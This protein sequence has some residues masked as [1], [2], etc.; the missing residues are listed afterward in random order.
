[1]VSGT[2]DF[3]P[4]ITETQSMVRIL[5]AHFEYHS[6]VLDVSFKILY[7]RFAFFV[8]SRRHCLP[9]VLNLRFP[10]ASPLIPMNLYHLYAQIYASLS[11]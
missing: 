2:I 6:S 9:C 11:V 1:M 10:V 3:H 5:I 8:Q 4:H 7:S